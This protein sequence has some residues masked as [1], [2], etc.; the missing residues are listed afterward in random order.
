MNI[1]VK[2]IY[3]F[4]SLRIACHVESVNYFAGLLGY[5]FPEHDNDKNSEPMRTG[6]AYIIY[7]MYHKNF[8]LLPEHE[9]LCHDAKQN[10]HKHSTHHAA[11]Y[12]NIADIPDVKIYEMV[13][14]WASA[15]F[16]QKNIIHVKD[17]ICLN[18]WFEQNN[19]QIPWTTH[20]LEI[21]RKSIQIIK[22]NTD[23]AY[24]QKIWKPVLEKSDL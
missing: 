23:Q 13:A 16:E 1:D 10:H 14:D 20:Q 18:E 15:N 21:I 5:H 19:A 7:A 24:V 4:S 3:E 17:A 8:H 9:Q 6:Y 2:D 11:Y 22:E 12:A